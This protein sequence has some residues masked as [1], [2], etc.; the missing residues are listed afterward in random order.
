MIDGS[1][2]L[3]PYRVVFTRWIGGE[4]RLAF[5][6]VNWSFGAGK[7]LRSIVERKVN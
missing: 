1:G 2:T 7:E 4:F 5:A 3:P 6:R